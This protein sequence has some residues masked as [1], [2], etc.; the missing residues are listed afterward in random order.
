[1]QPYGNLREGRKHNSPIKSAQWLILISDML[2]SQTSLA[3]NTGTSGRLL[4]RRMRWSS[5]RAFTHFFLSCSLQARRRNWAMM[6]GG[7]S[8][9]AATYKTSPKQEGYWCDCWRNGS[10]RQ[11]N[12]FQM[13]RKNWL[14]QSPTPHKICLHK[15]NY[16]KDTTL[17]QQL[18][19]KQNFDKTFWIRQICNNLV[20]RKQ[21][22]F[23]FINW[24]KIY[25][26]NMSHLE[27]KGNILTIRMN[28]IR[29]FNC[30]NLKLLVSAMSIR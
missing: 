26:S 12:I 1:M 22:K 29:F 28:Y 21:S 4:R 30:A 2:G 7:L 10:L 13:F 15:N 11:S 24:S 25:N 14:L 18:I 9:E 23:V 8:W 27:D 3:R 5:L 6:P 19:Y 20:N 17:L 16:N